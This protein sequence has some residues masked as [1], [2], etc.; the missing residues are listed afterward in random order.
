MKEK[1][2]ARLLSLALCAGLLAGC[3]AEEAKARLD[4]AGGHVREAIQ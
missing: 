1:I 4:K 3:G 2:S